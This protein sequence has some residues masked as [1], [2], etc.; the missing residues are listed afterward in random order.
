[1]SD[2]QLSLEADTQDYEESAVSPLTEL[3]HA[4]DFEVT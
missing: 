4:G 2:Q 1:M 3:G